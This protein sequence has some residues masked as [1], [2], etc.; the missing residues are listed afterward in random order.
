MALT[1]TWRR[2]SLIGICVLLTNAAVSAREHAQKGAMPITT[3]SREVRQLL[4]QAW[5]LNL[6]EVRQADAIE[7]LRK[8][9]KLDPNFAFGHELLSQCSLD[10]AEQVR[11]QQKAFAT[12]SHAGPAEQLVIDWFQN[13]AD[14]KLIPAITD[15]NEVLN[16]YPHDKWV[17][18][19]ANWWLTQQTQY[20]RAVA[21]FERSGIT[22]SPGL[23]NNTAYTYAY[24]RQFDRAFALM[25]RYVAALPENPNPQDSYAEILRLAGHFD[26]AIK[27]Y[28]AALALDPQFYSSQF[29]IAD[30]YSLMGDQRRAREEYRI[31][32]QKFPSL[33]ELHVIQWQTREAMTFV[34]ED[35]YAGADRAFQ[36]IAD[37][38]RAKAMS[39]VEADTYRQMA[40]Y[41]ADGK[42]A[43]ALLAKAE[44]AARQGENA[45]PFAI[46]QELAQILRARVEAAVKMGNKKM[47]NS[48][49]NRLADMSQRSNDKVIE[50]AYHGAAGAALFSEHKYNEAMSHLEEDINNPLSLKLLAMAYQKVGYGSEA[51]RVSKTLANLNDATLE[52]ALVVPTFRKCYESP[53]CSGNLKDAALK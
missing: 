17:V 2:V 24:M 23:M 33:P 3:K 6:D 8:A 25:E 14:H 7:V 51:K 45:M 11:E 26:Q 27:H 32:F 53:A 42:R 30:T 19:L 41:Q 39:Q 29:G 22:D 36:A 10:P 18:F 43:I 15:M 28:R 49:L 44:A 34:R 1:I 9:V 4:E 52:Q 31:A 21:V 50:T 35:D 38:A 48:V 47:A 46:Q 16:Q 13:A 20:D 12:R 40:M 37:R 5:R